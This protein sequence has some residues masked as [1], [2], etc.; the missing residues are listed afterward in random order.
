M[1]EAKMLPVLEALCNEVDKIPDAELDMN[2]IT[3]WRGCGCVMYHLK[4]N[5]ALCEAYDRTSLA[6]TQAQ[7]FRLYAVEYPY[8]AEV[9]FGAAAKAHFRAICQEISNDRA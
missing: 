7:D 3:G 1:T 4:K 5:P 9:Q 8:P 2:S 6:L